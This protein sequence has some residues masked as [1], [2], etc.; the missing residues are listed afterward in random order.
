MNA[1]KML[2]KLG[3]KKIEE[4]EFGAQYRKQ[5]EEYNYN[6]ILDIM[7]KANGQNLIQSYVEGINTDGFNDCVGVTYPEMKAAMKKYRELKRMYKWR[8]KC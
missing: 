3:F 4:N 1:D 6:Q 8:S 2:E 7:R 5:I